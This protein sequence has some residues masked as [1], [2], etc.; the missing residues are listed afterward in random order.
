V[1]KVLVIDDDPQLLHMVGLMLERG[2]HVSI[3]EADPRRG[4][5]CIREERPDLLI[6]DVMM[7]WI[8]G[9]ELCEQIRASEDIADLPVLILTAR[10]QQIDREAALESGADDYL[11]KP[12]LPRTLMERIDALLAARAAPAADQE[13]KVICLFSM[14]GGAGRTTVATNLAVSLRQLTRQEVCLVELSPSGGQVSTHLRLQPATTWATLPAPG[15]LTW[16]ALQETLLLHQSGLRLLA[17]PAHPDWEL[18]TAATLVEATLRLLQEQM[19]FIVVDLPPLLSPAVHAT[20]GMA[21]AI[22][23]L[24]APEIVSVQMGRLSAEGVRQHGVDGLM[25]YVLNQP[26]PESPLTLAA[27]EKGLRAE[28]THKIAHDP[29]QARALAQGVPL[30]LAA[31]QSPLAEATRALAD[32]VRERG[33]EQPLPITSGEETGAA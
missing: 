24:V 21:D 7:P 31:S 13:G 28:V 30:A 33:G 3:T 27:V 18:A 14:R 17:A 29:L 19:S 4:L 8:S 12:V 11:S 20:M 16:Q 2:G 5:Q 32:L 15:K 25:M 10:S 26:V 1:A 22:F 6:L 23:H 9:H